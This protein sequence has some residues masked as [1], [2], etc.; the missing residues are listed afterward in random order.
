[1][2]ARKWVAPRWPARLGDAAVLVAL[3]LAAAWLLRLQGT[4][5]AWQP[6]DLAQGL[7][8]AA[9]TAAW[10]LWCAG[11]F[12]RR[13]LAA[14]Q[15]TRPAATSGRVHAAGGNRVL[16]AHASQTGYAEQLA[17]RTAESLRKSGLTADLMPLAA[18]D[19]ARLRAAGRV[20]LVASTTGEG[21]APDAAAA[22]VRDVLAEPA[23]LRGLRYGLL[24]LGDREYRNYCGF[25]RRLD[26]WLRHGGAEPLFDPVEV[27]DGDEGALRH[28]QHHLG[29]L[30]G[31]TDLA[32]WS[33]P[34]YAQWRLRGRRLLNPGSV[35]GACFHLE[36]E[37]V[38]G[39]PL[40]WQAGDIA[41]VGPCH[42]DAT[43]EA[44]LQAL[45][46]RGVFDGD[47]G[48]RRGA[49]RERLACSVLP[50]LDALRG[51]DAST[52]AA[53]L[54]PLP[55]REYSIA[56]IPADGAIHLLV[57]RMQRPDGSPGLGSGWLTTY[58][59]IGGPIRLRVRT[60]ANFHV[61]GD[62]RPLIM[63]GNGSGI[64]GLR[65]LLKQRIASGHRRNWLLFGE[66]NVAR[67]F[68]YGEEIVHWRDQGCIERLDLAFSRDQLERVYV[69]Q[70][71]AESA[72][73]LRAWIDEGA[74]VYV[75]GSLKGMAPGVHAVLAEV[76]DAKVVERL[77]AEGRY[78]RDVY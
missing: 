16:V 63:V 6:P 45:A 29:L 20:L 5:P 69:Q 9:A 78:R 3:A 62:A 67:D 73:V 35:G 8:A 52:L 15:S 75:C 46:A 68:H 19:E 71:L 38:D 49:L 47:T 24:A 26:A 32:D 51:I 48:E 43:V 61:P 30:A 14:R 13:V 41:E 42:R 58:A 34:H 12:A 2:S 7:T 23:D 31:D 50:P 56:S 33:A 66:R 55:H 76:L 70:R 77:Q 27:D 22:F 54:R 60:N 53:Q 74:A 4:L 39:A 10:L 57:R 25:G 65:A 1:M 37:P 36:L 11:A 21:D 40:H 59:P 44:Y 18:V 72:S 17:R 28:W 64:A